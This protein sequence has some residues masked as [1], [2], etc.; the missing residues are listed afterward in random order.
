MGPFTEGWAWST[1]N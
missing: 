1:C